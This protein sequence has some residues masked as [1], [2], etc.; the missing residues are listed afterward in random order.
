[1]LHYP[2]IVNFLDQVFEKPRFGGP[3]VRFPELISIQCR[4]FETGA[5][6]GRAL[7]KVLRDLAK[8][9][10]EPGMHDVLASHIT[11]RAQQR[12]G[13]Y[14]RLSGEPKSMFDFFLFTEL[15]GKG[16]P[17]DAIHQW[18]NKRV[19]LALAYS[20]CSLSMVEGIGVWVVYPELTASMWN[21]SWDSMD[22]AVWEKARDR[23]LLIEKPTLPVSLDDRQAIVLE[24]LLFSCWL[25]PGTC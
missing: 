2:F 8:T 22:N 3:K 15:Q 10:S 11:E 23:G 24:A 25:L 4:L 19:D 21:N 9:F 16:A 18:K 20:I 7:R 5:V 13:W 17:E 12:V 6:L 1:M 14:K